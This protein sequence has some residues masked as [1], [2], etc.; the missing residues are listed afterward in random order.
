MKQC[1]SCGVAKPE[2]RFYKGR[3]TCKDCHNK[4]A[5]D[6]YHANKDTRRD[7][8]LRRLYGIDLEQYNQM[9]NEQEGCCACCGRHQVEFKRRLAV[10]HCHS[11]GRV[12]A[13][14]CSHCNTAYGSLEEN[15]ERIHQLL[16]YHRRTQG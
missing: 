3:N 7:Q 8:N 5:N 6:R 4:K 13:L 11:T 14:L 15:E 16:Q 2:E 1:R 10:D 12:R 9:F